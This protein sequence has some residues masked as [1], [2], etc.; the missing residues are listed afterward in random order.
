MKPN[1]AQFSLLGL[2][3]A[4]TGIGMVAAMGVAG[5]RHWFTFGAVLL[6]GCVLL[7]FGFRW[8]IRGKGYWPT[9]ARGGLLYIAALILLPLLVLLLGGLVVDGIGNQRTWWWPP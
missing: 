7:W 4:L 3:L 5:G 1:L 2:L 8:A 6:S 9:G